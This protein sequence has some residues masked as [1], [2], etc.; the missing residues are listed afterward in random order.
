[1]QRSRKRIRRIDAP[2][3]LLMSRSNSGEGSSDAFLAALSG[4]G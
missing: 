1:M 3:D 4:G 2:V